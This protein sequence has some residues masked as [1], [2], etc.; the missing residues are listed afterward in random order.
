MSSYKLDYYKDNFTNFLGGGVQVPFCC[1][2]EEEF[3]GWDCA[4]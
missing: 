2:N 4:Q 3:T 1:F